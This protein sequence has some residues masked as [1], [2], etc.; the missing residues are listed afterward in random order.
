[1]NPV[2]TDPL[3]PSGVIFIYSV[4]FLLALLILKTICPENKKADYWNMV[5]LF[6]GINFVVGYWIVNIVF[7]VFGLEIIQGLRLV[8]DEYWDNRLIPPPNATH[9]ATQDEKWATV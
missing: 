5:A 2:S 4:S 3:L 9:I 6:S 8:P 7:I 1:M